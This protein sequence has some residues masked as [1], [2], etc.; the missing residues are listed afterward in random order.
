M[1]D[2]SMAA[3]SSGCWG[4]TEAPNVVCSLEAIVSVSG[5]VMV[6]AS[7]ESSLW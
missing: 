2:E 1:V 5:R 7:V 4:T 6:R 3:F